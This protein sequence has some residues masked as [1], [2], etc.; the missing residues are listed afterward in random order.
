MFFP[1]LNI[2]LLHGHIIIEST[3]MIWKKI[4][5]HKYMSF[6]EDGVYPAIGFL[7]DIICERFAIKPLKRR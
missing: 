2:L 7:H 4:S 6:R 3:L 1:N 5:F